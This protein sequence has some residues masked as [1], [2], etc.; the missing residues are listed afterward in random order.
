MLPG[1]SRP[2]CLL[3]EVDNGTETQRQLLNKLPGYHALLTRS[4][5][6]RSWHELTDVPPLAA[7]VVFLFA[8]EERKEN[9]CCTPFVGPVL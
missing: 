6:E 7:R 5:F 8:S 3:L 1:S 4:G 2:L 9:V